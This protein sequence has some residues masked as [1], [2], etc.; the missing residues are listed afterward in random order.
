MR[1]VKAVLKKGHERKD[2][3]DLKDYFPIIILAPHGIRKIS[4]SGAVCSGNAHKEEN[5]DAHRIDLPDPM[6]R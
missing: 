2:Q 1:A 5:I 6:R 4:A 3:C